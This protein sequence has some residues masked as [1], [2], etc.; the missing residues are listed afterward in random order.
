M[1]CCP[2][3]EFDKDKF[4]FMATLKGTVKKVSLEHF[5]RPRTSGIIALDLNEGDRL[6]GAEL[7]DGNKD[8]M[9][10]SDAG[11]V[12]RFNE[13]H[14]RAMGRLAR[15]VRGIRLSDEQRMIALLVVGEER[16]KF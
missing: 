7:T 2:L 14:V 15:G 8:V 9:L 1:R 11:K 4:V 3:K 16:L 5:S 13:S 10:F 12:V 6:I